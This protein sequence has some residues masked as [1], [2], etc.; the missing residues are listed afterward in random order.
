M[1]STE[2]VSSSN[3]LKASRILSFGATIFGAAIS[4][5]PYAADFNT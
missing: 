2:T 5:C 1:N 4:W 3:Q